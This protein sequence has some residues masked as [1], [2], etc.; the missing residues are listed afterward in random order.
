MRRLNLTA[1]LG[2]VVVVMLSVGCAGGEAADSPAVAMSAVSTIG[3]AAVVLAQS[4]TWTPSSMPPN[5]QDRVA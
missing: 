5:P 2:S 1:L 4:K 3:S